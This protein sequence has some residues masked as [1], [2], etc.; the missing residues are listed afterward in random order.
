MRYKLLGVFCIG[1]ILLFIL[2]AKTVAIENKDSNTE[3]TDERAIEI[4]RE[5]A[6][7]MYLGE[8]ISHEVSCRESD[9]YDD[10][11]F[12]NQEYEEKLYVYHRD[13]IKD[14]AYN[15]LCKLYNIRFYR[16][17]HTQSRESESEFSNCMYYRIYTK[18]KFHIKYR[19]KKS[20]CV[21]IQFIKSE[22][23]AEDMPKISDGEVYFELCEDNK[24]RISKVLQWYDDLA[25]YDLGHGM[26]LFFDPEYSLLSDY[27]EFIEKYGY[28]SKG[29]RIS[30]YIS[31]SDNGEFFP[32]SAT[33]IISG[34]SN[35]EKLKKLSKFAACM[36]REE[37]YARHGKIYTKNSPEYNYFR[38]KRWYEK[39]EN[40]SENDLSDIEKENIKTISEYIDSF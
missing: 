25:Y 5:I 34:T 15:Y 8:K 19:D 23:L 11:Y 2:N 35:L 7:F 1:V 3:M 4:I 20:I 30:M 18:G 17:R 39:N 22:F 26:R 14:M 32:G 37:I 12:K 16:G 33:E 28:D 13:Y 31:T 36:A 6:D 29:N 38:T 24:W 21:Q 27:E 9:G 40:F 10:Y